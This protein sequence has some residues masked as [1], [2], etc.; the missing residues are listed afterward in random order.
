ME[1]WLR[2][3]SNFRAGRND[4]WETRHEQVRVRWMHLKKLKRVPGY[5]NYRNDSRQVRKGGLAR[6]LLH[7]KSLC[8]EPHLWQWFRD[9]LLFSVLANQL[10]A[11]EHGK[12]P[13]LPTSCSLLFISV[14]ISSYL[15]CLSVTVS[16]P[17][18]LSLT[19]MLN[20]DSALLEM[21]WINCTCRPLTRHLIKH[22]HSTHKP[23][24]L[25]K[26]HSN[27]Q[28]ENAMRHKMEASLWSSHF[29]KI[30]CSRKIWRR[31]QQPGEFPLI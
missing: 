7:F 31:Y 19:V 1:A 2:W 13:V 18:S 29:Q 8:A 21:Q 24:T 23:C 9:G 10:K 11:S 20:T 16:T 26:V 6:C 14:S 3:F 28:C 5:S 17:V 4:P 12:R 22:T 30:L 25:R 27:I 15:I